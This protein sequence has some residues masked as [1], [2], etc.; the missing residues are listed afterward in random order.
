MAG[1]TKWC[2]WRSS[3][4]L[5]PSEGP[6]NRRS[7]AR[8]WLSAIDRA[9]D[10]VCYTFGNVP[11]SQLA[12]QALVIS[13]DAGLQPY[14]I[15]KALRHLGH[16][17]GCHLILEQ[18]RHDLFAKN[19][20]HDSEQPHSQKELS[21][22][23]C[24]RRN[25]IH[26]NLGR[27]EQRRFECGC[28]AGNDCSARIS[29][30]VVGFIPQNRDWARL[31]NA[32][33]ETRIEPGRNRQ[34]ELRIGV[35]RCQQFGR[36]TQDGKDEPD[37]FTAAA[38]KQSNDRFPWIQ[39]MISAKFF[40]RFCRADHVHKWVT[41]ELHFDAGLPVKFFFEGKD[42]QHLV[43]ELFDLLDAAGTPCPNLGADVVKDRRAR[44]L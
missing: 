22:K 44:L 39:S 28:A 35:C 43:D 24:G 16:G 27:T 42:D 21:Q 6:S 8:S 15:H 10:S 36:L 3:L 34:D 41:D 1:F 12:A 5:R 23:P 9:C 29:N 11:R 40:F 26:D 13:S 4:R 14:V 2:R 33:D 32:L 25:S 7:F 19:D 18:L 38:R 37:F 31:D 17:G 30:R 20:I